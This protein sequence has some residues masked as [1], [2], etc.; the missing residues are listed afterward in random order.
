[1][2]FAIYSAEGTS[3]SY[4]AR[5]IDEGEEVLV[6]IAPHAQKRNG[7]GLVPK[8]TSYDELVQW[9]S[10]APS[11]FIFDGSGHGA[12]A[13]D[14]RKKGQL[15]IGGGLFMDALEQKRAWGQKLAKS[16]GIAIPK[17]HEF[18]SVSDAMTFLKSNDTPWVFKSNKYLDAS[19]TFVSK[20]ADELYKY[21]AYIK[22]KWGDRIPNHLEAL[23]DGEDIS[24]AGWWNGK[25]FLYPLE[26]TIEHKKFMDGDVGPSTGCSM[27]L[28]WMYDKYPKIAEELNWTE[29]EGLFRRMDAP[30]GLYDINARINRDDGNKPYFLE[31]TPRFGYDSEPTAQMGLLIPLGEFF[32]RLA[33]GGIDETP[34]TI[35]ECMMSV[36][37]SVPP[38]PWETIDDIDKKKTCVGTPV[39]GADGLW[40]E[41]GKHFIG[42]GLGL[43]KHDEL[44]VVDPTGL[45]GLAGA[46][47][48]N[49]DAMSKEILGFIKDD[50]QIPNLG[51]RHD[52]AQRISADLKALKKLGYDCSPIIEPSEDC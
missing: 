40:A 39:F 47:G 19:S 18:N 44:Q 33:K 42:Y 48:T 24:T 11:V 7:E 21:L 23:I 4:W 9:G 13:D 26:G 36:R 2:R 46:R 34:F 3:L 27:N 22:G 41:D 1:M 16:L 51:Y 12:K 32:Y 38:Y 29:V 52:F 5:L 6:Y 20:S 17:S 28:I 15:V 35:D 10:E 49:L 25:S 37:L 43:D 30:P 8:T 31:W 14:L 45:V 50:L